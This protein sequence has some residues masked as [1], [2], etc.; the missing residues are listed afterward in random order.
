VLSEAFQACR[1]KGRVVLVGDVGMNINRADIY[2]KELDF[3]ISTSYGPGRYDPTYEEGGMDYPVAYV[4]WTENRN[5]EAYLRMLAERRIRLDNLKA[6]PFDV[7]RAPEAY[8]ALKGDGEKPLLVLLRYPERQEAENRTIVHRQAVER[9]GKI[10]VAVAGASSFAQSVHLP[11]MGGVLRDRYTVRAVMSRTGSNAKAIATQYQAE[12]STTDYEKV[13]QDPDVDLVMVT[14]RNDLHAGFALQA[15]RA[16]KN[17]FVEKPLA[18]SELEL[19]E[20]RDFFLATGNAP[21]LM[22]GFNRR[23]SP[24]L[25][26]TAEI[27]QKRTTPLI[28]NYR[29]NAGFLPA[30]HWAHGPEGGGRNI[31]EACHIYDVFNFLTGARVRSVHA[32][33]INPAGRQWRRNDNFVATIEFDDGS[34]CTLTYTAMGAKAFPKERME[35]FTSGWVISLDDYKSLSVTGLKHKGWSASSIDKGQMQELAELAESLKKGGA[36]PIPLEQQ[37]QATEISFEVER[38]VMGRQRVAMQAAD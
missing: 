24:A 7:D 3:F 32:S 11:N 28:V 21:L 2:K 14:M 8:E 31:A 15:L 9:A 30:D 23:F 6:A 22:T 18:I 16:G 4:R 10:R 12:Y 27:L 37:L 35:I 5:M 29:M 26:V 17:V 20:I 36:W 38:Q 1:K 34:V 19:A 13:L 33:A 25:K